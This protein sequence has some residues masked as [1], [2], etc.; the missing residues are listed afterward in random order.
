[1]GIWDDTSCGITPSFRV[2]AT[3]TGPRAPR[4]LIVCLG[5]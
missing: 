2:V 5:Y 3:A 4:T 1:M